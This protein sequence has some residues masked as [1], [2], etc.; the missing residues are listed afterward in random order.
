MGLPANEKVGEDLEIEYKSPDPLTVKIYDEDET[1]YTL[2]V[3]DIAASRTF[4][5]FRLKDIVADPNAE[6]LRSRRFS[7]RIEGSLSGR[8]EVYRVE[9]HWYPETRWAL[10]FDSI[11][12][13]LGVPAG[14]LLHWL[15][16]DIENTAN[17]SFAI[18]GALES[19]VTQIFTGTITGTGRRSLEL[20]LEANKLIARLVRI[21]MW[22]T[23]HFKLHDLKL[24]V[25]PVPVVV[26]NNTW[27]SAEVPDGR[28]F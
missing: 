11:I 13:D 25:T 16:V 28:L 6:G 17:V 1:E 2:G 26:K 3:L 15:K 20:T 22:S 27:R 18:D 12:S 14:K 10:S 23:S 7:V 21:R 8:A 9:L 4:K 24:R 5:I 19:A